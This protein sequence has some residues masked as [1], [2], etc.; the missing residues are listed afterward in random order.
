[1][2]RWDFSKAGLIDGSSHRSLRQVGIGA[3]CSILLLLILSI[4]PTLRMAGTLVR[5]VQTCTIL[6]WPFGGFCRVDGSSGFRFAYLFFCVLRF[7]FT[8]YE[9]LVSELVYVKRKMDKVY[10]EIA[11]L[12]RTEAVLVWLA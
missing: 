12:M 5:G 8:M 1:M 6:L 2:A 3:F 9:G 4:V 10:T 11:N 7:M